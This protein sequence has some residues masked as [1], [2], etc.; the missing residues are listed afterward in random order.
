VGQSSELGGVDQQEQD[1]FE[2]DP[3]GK[4]I[5]QPNFHALSSSDRLLVRSDVGQ[6]S[7]L[8][9]SMSSGVPPAALRSSLLSGNSLLVGGPMGPAV[10]PDP[11]V[12]MSGVTIS[13][14]MEVM[15]PAR[16]QPELNQ[17][18]SK[19]R[20]DV[21]ADLSQ[22]PTDILRA[23]SEGRDRM[24]RLFGPC[25]EVS[26]EVHLLGKGIFQGSWLSLG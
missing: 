7:D 19:S 21:L 3:K 9:A 13:E 16:V 10:S 18:V 15:S 4:A 25:S 1:C 6:F 8:E 11:V 5:A 23:V 12:L 24:S 20:V 17:A 14:L 2:P 22:E 26:G